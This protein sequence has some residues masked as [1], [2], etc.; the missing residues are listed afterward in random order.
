MLSLIVNVTTEWGIGCGGELLVT[1]PA[2]MKRFRELTTGKTVL[3]GRLTLDTFPGGR[4]LKNRRNIILSADPE[5]TVEGADVVH[6]VAELDALLRTVQ[7]EVVVIGGESIYRLML[8][9]CDR[10]Y[11]TRTYG[12][13][14]ADRFFPDLDKDPHWRQ[15]DVSPLMEHEG[16]FFRYIDYYRA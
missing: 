3:L 2:D 13:F 10:A 11:I 1:I 9:R 6:T 8:D 5:D 7:E 15:G 14:Q 16:I 4:P 12:E